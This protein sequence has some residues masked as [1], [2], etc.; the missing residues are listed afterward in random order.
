MIRDHLFSGIG[1]GEQAFRD[2]YP[3]YAIPGT[4]TVMHSHN[5]FMQIA[6]ELGIIGLLIFVFILVMYMQKAFRCVGYRRNESKS[7]ITV[8]AGFAGIVGACVAGFTDHIWYNY[9][10][11]LIFWIV[12]ALTMA[13]ARI[14]E[15]ERFKENARFVNNSRSADL[16]L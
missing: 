13:F 16:D 7:R 8:S 2:V 14:D 6:L 15:R 12:V 9:R 5:I 4:E 10:V 1:V 11:F 3:A